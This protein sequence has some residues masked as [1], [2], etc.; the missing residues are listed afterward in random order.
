MTARGFGCLSIGTP[1]G[2][3]SL[4]PGGVRLFSTVQA[5]I[6][7]DPKIRWDDSYGRLSVLSWWAEK[8]I[9]RAIPS[10]LTLHGGKNGKC[11]RSHKEGI[12]VDLPSVPA[13][14]TLYNS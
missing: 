5:A 1:H 12:A 3:F 2:K 10:G 8:W 6:P 11:A 4:R 7:A 9:S 13:W 14:I